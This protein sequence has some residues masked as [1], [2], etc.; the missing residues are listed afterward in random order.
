MD[1]DKC[2]VVAVVLLLGAPPL[3]VAGMSGPGW[4][5]VE[6][7]L[8]GSVR[9]D[10]RDFDQ[11]QATL[12]Y[13]LPDLR[14]AGRR[15]PLR[16]EALAGAFQSRDDQQARF[17]AAGLDLRYRPMGGPVTWSFGSAAA[18][19]DRH[20]FHDI[21]FGGDFQF[22]SHLGLSVG[23]VAGV[24]FSLR[25]QHMSNGG[26]EKPNPGLDTALLGVKWLF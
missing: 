3:A 11:I 26:M 22:I 20:L 21:D 7:L 25:L 23:L 4:D 16:V 18:A 19:T 12:A 13:R 2:R 9:A 14:V 1:V 24:G 5:G 17:L 6:L 15:L 8:G 10:K